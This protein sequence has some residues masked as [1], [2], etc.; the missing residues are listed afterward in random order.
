MHFLNKM[1]ITA[2]LLLTSATAARADL[3]VT[4]GFNGGGLSSLGS[5]GYTTIGEVF[6]VPTGGYTQI[7]SFGFNIRGNLFE[8][9]GGVATWTGTG[10]GPALFTSSTFSAN[11]GHFAEVTVNTGGVGLTPGQEYVAYFSIAGIAGDTGQD[12]MLTGV[13]SAIN[14][15]LASDFSNG[16]NPNHADW[17][18]CQ[19]SKCSEVSLAYTIDFAQP[20]QANVPEPATAL[21]LGPG[22][23]GLGAVRRRRASAA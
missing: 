21:L 16:G 4:D 12:S 22:L 23:I 8:A 20:T 18:G 11:L 2:L 5:P 9:Y 3:I 13:S 1:G 14:V 6:T 17:N 7:D 10:A 15:G 19:G